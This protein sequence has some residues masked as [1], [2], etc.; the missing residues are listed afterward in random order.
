MSLSPVFTENGPNLFSHVSSVRDTLCLPI[1]QILFYFSGAEKFCHA[2]GLR[3]LTRDTKCDVNF[4]V[5]KRYV[6]FPIIGKKNNQT[7]IS[8]ADREIPTL[9]STDNTR[10]SLNLV[11]GISRLPSGWDFSICIS[12]RC[13]SIFI[14]A[15]T[16]S[17]T[18]VN[19]R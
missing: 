19:V 8:D 5:Y 13:K 6:I 3:Q 16:S 4:F 11:S 14:L 1:R 10:N 9:G 15:L 17:Y 18:I 2:H 12:D 7:P